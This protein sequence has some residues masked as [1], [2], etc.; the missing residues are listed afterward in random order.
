MCSESQGANARGHVANEVETEQIVHDASTLSPGSPMT[1]YVQMR[2]SVPCFW[3]QVGLCAV[4]RRLY[5]SLSLSLYLYLPAPL[6]LSLF[7]S[8]VSLCLSF[9]CT[10][11]SCH[12]VC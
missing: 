10:P 1:S 3:A 7:F 9:P 4:Y 11:R 5:L 2:G 12:A 6:C 8:C